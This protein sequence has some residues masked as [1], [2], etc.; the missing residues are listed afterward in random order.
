M[1]TF[2]VCLAVVVVSGAVVVRIVL[3]DEPRPPAPPRQG[4]V[5]PRASTTPEPDGP[6]R[7]W[8]R[9][10][11][12]RFVEIFALSGF[13]VAQPV[14][15]SFGESPETFV[16]VDASARIIVAF[17]AAVV[18]TP[19][20]AL[21]GLVAAT[22]L[23]GARVRQIAQSTAIGVLVGLFVSL[24]ARPLV[25]GPLLLVVAALAAGLVA[26][27]LYERFAAARLY[28]LFAST[29]PVAFL[30]LFLVS[31]P[32]TNLVFTP[33]RDPVMVSAASE[34]TSGQPSVVIVVLDELPTMSLLDGSNRIDPELFP[35]FARFADDATFYRNTT[36]AATFTVVAMPALLTGRIPSQAAAARN[37]YVENLFT[38]LSPTHVLNVHE[39]LTSLCPPSQCDQRFDARAIGR[40]GSLAWHLWSAIVMPGAEGPGNEGAGEDA[41]ERSHHDFWEALAPM[42]AGRVD[43]VDDF[44]ESLEPEGARPRLDFAHL[45]FPHVPW[46]RLPSGHR[47][48]GDPIPLGLRHPRWTSETA[49]RLGRQRHLLQLQYTDQQVGKVLDRLEELDRYDD[50]YVIFL[51]DH[52]ISFQDQQ[53]WRGVSGENEHE[54]LWVPLLIKAPG[55]TEGRFTDVNSQTTD[56]VPTIADAMGISIDW[57]LDGRSLLAG[58]PRPGGDKRFVPDVNQGQLKPD[59]GRSYA[60]ID[61]DQGFRS[62]LVAPPAS[63]V[64]SDDPLALYHLPPHLDLTGTSVDDLPQGPPAD[65]KARL[66][67]GGRYDDVDVGA[68]T[69][70]VYISGVVEEPE[71]ELR[72]VVVAVNGVIGGWG[73]LEQHYDA[74]ETRFAVLV[75][76]SFLRPGAN[77]VE[78]FAM[79][80]PPGAVTLRPVE[81]VE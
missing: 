43:Q 21:W 46:D 42:L 18:L 24:S 51:A 32:V 70:P 62:M 44:L 5:R 15:A 25:P 9:R 34:G 29:G 17:G 14:L 4:D 74:D 11:G 49:G 81:L 12:R 33:E 28:L 30:A 69:V 20:L 35:N 7:P 76:E 73:R 22:G 67:D 27:V 36:T 75:P 48:E 50:S 26:A 59:E 58:A 40:L 61:G 60:T 41:V 37:D 54:L 19:A 13:V 2:V 71:T 80:G 3:L 39:P 23:A 45:L 66:I 72:D 8:W 16:S 38:L 6:D 65:W 56:L 47:Y 79:E 55:Q 57:E 78:V 10:E 53:V 63:A 68:A 1:L 31:S 77:T 52:G 64:P